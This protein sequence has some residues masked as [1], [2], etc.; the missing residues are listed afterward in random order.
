MASNFRIFIHR[1]NDKLHLRLVGD[2][3]GTSAFE[4]MRKDIEVFLNI[5]MLYHTFSMSQLYLSDF[6][7]FIY[8]S[9]WWHTSCKE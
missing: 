5:P 1:N 3:D 2:F 7:R 9:A 8:I 6:V 4:F